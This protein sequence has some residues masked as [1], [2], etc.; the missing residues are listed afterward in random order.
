MGFVRVRLFAVLCSIGVLSMISLVGC[1][2]NPAGY[3]ETAPV[4]GTVTLD[5]APVEGAS[6]SFA[7]PEGRS[8][9]GT[10]DADGKYELRYVGPVMGAML[11]TNRVIIR[12][13][14]PDPD[15]VPTAAERKAAEEMA[16][17]DP[18][19]SPTFTSPMI[20]SLPE[21]YRSRDSELSADVKDTDNVFDF[22]LTSD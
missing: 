4:T 16:A 8:S 12:K 14:V 22:A 19:E 18:D 1:G 6:I 15:Y 13:Q 5:G 20:D 10:T 9:S 17:L 11:G 3:P 2:G 7:P 21:R